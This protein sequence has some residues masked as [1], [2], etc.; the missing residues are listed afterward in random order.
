MR[1]F[2]ATAGFV[3][4]SGIVIFSAPAQ[5][6]HKW[7]DEEGTPHYSDQKPASDETEVNEIEVPSG[8]TVKTES[9]ETNT[10]I[11]DQLQKMQQDRAKREQMQQEEEK[12]RAIE[13]SLQQ[14]ALIPEESRKDKGSGRRRPKQLPN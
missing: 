6:V 14:E 4:L 12:A 7:V 11:K 3:I 10:R 8:D 5:T 9:E 2:I 13:E 1:K